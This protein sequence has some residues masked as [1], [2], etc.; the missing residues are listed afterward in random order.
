MTLTNINTISDKDLIELCI[1]NLQTTV[2][3]TTMI[4]EANRKNLR[5]YNEAAQA[6]AF[7]KQAREHM[8]IIN[9]FYRRI[10]D[11]KKV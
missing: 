7:L 3:Y 6:V 2:D 8:K 4:K 1:E 9:G 10:S 5:V 11:V